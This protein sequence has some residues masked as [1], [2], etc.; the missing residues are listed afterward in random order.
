MNEDY[1]KLMR[2]PIQTEVTRHGQPYVDEPVYKTFKPRQ[3]LVSNIALGV[4]S[5]YGGAMPQMK[6]GVIGYTRVFL[7]WGEQK[8]GRFKP[9]YK[10]R[11]ELLKYIEE[12]SPSA[13]G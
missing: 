2:A 10:D 12:N 11:E 8:N 13:H 3:E 7:R 4:I 5:A 1:E 6:R 9:R